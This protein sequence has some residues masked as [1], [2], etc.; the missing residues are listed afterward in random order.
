MAEF[1]NEIQPFCNNP[2]VPQND[3]KL[4]FGFKNCPTLCEAISLFRANFIH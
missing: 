3:L 2:E 4:K 1:L